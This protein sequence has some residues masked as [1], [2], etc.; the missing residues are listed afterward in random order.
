[1]SLYQ[2]NKVKL[3]LTLLFSKFEVVLIPVLRAVACYMW[4]G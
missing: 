4:V 1:M 3:I 2:I